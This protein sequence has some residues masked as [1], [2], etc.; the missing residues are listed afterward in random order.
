MSSWYLAASLVQLTREVNEKMAP[1]VWPTVSVGDGAVGDP[2][3]Q[4]RYSSHNP[5]ATT[6]PPWAVRA[7]DIGI[8][9]RDAR[10]ILNEVIGDPRVWYVIHKGVIYSRTYDWAANRYTGSNPHDH[11]IHISLVESETAYDDTSRWFGPRRKTR[12]PSVDLSLL[13]ARFE[14]GNANPGVAKVQRALNAEYG[15]DLATDGLAGRQTRQAWR[16]HERR[17]DAA[18]PNGIPNEKTLR[19]LARGRFAV[20][21]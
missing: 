5:L 20:R 17:I 21:P 3:H 10:A 18:K 4:A 16:M 8:N 13:R 11:H 6:N 19:A 1:P 15:L 12:G 9:G 14:D 7:V 2:S